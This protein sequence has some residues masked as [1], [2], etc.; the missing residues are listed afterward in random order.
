M[1]FCWCVLQRAKQEAESEG[2]RLILNK[3]ARERETMMNQPCAINALPQSSAL[4]NNDSADEV[5]MSVVD[6]EILISAT[7]DDDV[8]YSIPEE[9]A[10]EERIHS[11]RTESATLTPLKKRLSELHTI[12]IV[13]RVPIRC[14][15][16]ILS[17][18]RQLD[19]ELNACFPQDCRTLRPPV[20]PH[21]VRSLMPGTFMYFGIANIL[22]IPGVTLFDQSVNEIRLSVNIDGV[23]LHQHANGTGFWPIL[24]SIDE[25]PP[26]LIGL[27]EGKAKPKCPNEFLLEFI[28]EVKNLRT[29]GLTLNGKT[30]R[31]VLHCMIM[32]APAMSY[33][34]GVK[35]HSGYYGCTKCRVEGQLVTLHAGKTKNG[36]DKKAV[37]F[38]DMDAELRHA[39]DFRMHYDLADDPHQKCDEY[40]DDEDD[41]NDRDFVDSLPPEVRKHHIH[42]S[43]LV[44]IDGFDPIKDIPLDYMHLVLLGLMKRLLLLWTS[45]GAYKLT[46]L[47]SVVERMRAAIPYVPNEFQ[48]DLEDSLQYISSWKA[49]QFR[50]FLLYIGP[51]VLSGDAMKNK[52][53]FQHF[54]LLAVC[55]RILARRVDNTQRLETLRIRGNQVKPW[56]RT[57]VKRSIELY[58][59]DFAVYTVHNLIHMAD[60]YIHFGPV[61]R[62]SAFKYESCNGRVKKLVTGHCKPSIQ[63]VNKYSSLL[64]TGQYGKEGNRHTDCVQ[65][66]YEVPELENRVEEE[67][68]D[69]ND[70]AIY[71]QYT[72][73]RFRNFII[74][75]DNK[76]DSYCA[77]VNGEFMKVTKILR[78][79]E[80]KLMYICGHIFGRT[81]SLF[82]LSSINYNSRDCGI[83]IASELSSKLYRRYYG[84]ITEKCVAAP[85][86]DTTDGGDDLYGSEF[87]IIKFLH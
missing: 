10:E 60:D 49:T 76:C 31:F 16:A 80:T 12:F 78:H 62:Y 45:P 57:F 84:K 63:V 79:K 73:M 21:T 85:Y 64:Q 17:F 7:N 52:E 83:V 74:R 22:T 53:H 37:R 56:M 19:P 81:R 35:G 67:D 27:Y 75:T 38:I 32:D 30:Y 68:N 66:Y 50:F 39:D 34:T 28:N 25:F 86:N 3:W 36:R 70:T 4:D 55:M 23:P 41:E 13:H 6:D 2:V 40:D 43:A 46:D 5:C 54:L 29:N 8:E 1:S 82:F 42:P 69:E 26:F 59:M 18:I 24:G 77:L 71:E 11:T 51:V 33:I 61:D 58:T 44:E 65:E 87:A 72:R 15:N 47:S 14:Q 48:R 20:I 9:E